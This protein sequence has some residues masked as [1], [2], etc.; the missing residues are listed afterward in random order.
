MPPKYSEKP[1]IQEDCDVTASSLGAY[2]EIGRG[3]RL[4]QVVLGD[5]SY[6]DRFADIA[7][8][9]IGK[10]S[11]IASYARIGPTDHPMELAA[12]HHFHYRS[13]DY[14]DDAEYDV[15][16]FTRRRSRIVH[17][18]HDTWIGHNAVI[19]PEVTIGDGAVIAAGAVVTKDVAPYQIV[20][21]VP[22]KPMRNRFPEPI[23][24]RL[25]DLAWWD[26]DHA[27][28]RERLD[29]FRK[30]PAAEFLEKYE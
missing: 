19:R 28:L 15:D 12:L 13:S 16:F 30:L 27:T 3:S 21:G 23:A 26:W 4:A 5:Y 22:A 14:W 10:F 11:N 29:D 6:C 20:G 8:A 1:L 24:S 18:G 2:T 25:I 17:I 9:V 7:N